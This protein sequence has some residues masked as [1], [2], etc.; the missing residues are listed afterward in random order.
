MAIID[1]LCSN[2][3]PIRDDFGC[4]LAPCTVKLNMYQ[5]VPEITNQPNRTDQDRIII[6]SQPAGAHAPR[7]NKAGRKLGGRGIKQA[8]SIS[9]TM[10]QFTRPVSWFQ[11]CWPG[12]SS[13]CCRTTAAAAATQLH[14]RVC[15]RR[16]RGSH[17]E[18][19]LIQIKSRSQ[20]RARKYHTTHSTGCTYHRPTS[21]TV[22]RP[23][24]VCRSYR[25]ARDLAALL[26]G[27]HGMVF[28]F[29]TNHRFNLQCTYFIFIDHFWMVSPRLGGERRENTEQGATPFPIKWI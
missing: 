20:G 19:A 10:D 24:R 16:L 18:A 11:R 27:Q 26:A 7:T 9:P 21:V 28:C 22:S 13:A 17:E 1:N 25:I 2:R 12:Q 3:V 15:R 8:G 23:V 5:H 6:V 4:I 14:R 29:P